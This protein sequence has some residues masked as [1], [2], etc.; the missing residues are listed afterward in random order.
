MFPFRV[1]FSSRLFW[2]LL[3]VGSTLL[4]TG[5]LRRRMTINSNPPGATVYVDGHQLGRTPVST[6]FTYYG[7]RNIRLE[8]DNYQ[9]LEVHQAVRPPWYQ[10]PPFDFFVETFSPNEIKDQHTWTYNMTPRVVSSPEQI[11]ER[12]NELAYEGSRVVYDNG[13]VGP[14]VLSE[15]LPENQNLSP[16]RPSTTTPNLPA[17]NSAPQ[18]TT[19]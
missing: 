8:L 17:G 11:L 3:L 14:P 6:D 16:P 15:N 2:T 4:A 5:C 10:L 9:T 12:G 19:P 7:T 13:R 1:P 18:F